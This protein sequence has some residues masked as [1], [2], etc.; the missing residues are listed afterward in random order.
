LDGKR[1]GRSLWSAEADGA[2]G[3]RQRLSRLGLALGIVDGSGARK[4][5][6]STLAAA[7]WASSSARIKRSMA[8]KA[9][10]VDVVR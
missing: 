7:H 5:V 4:T 10:S 3:S 6:F 1:T 9:T 2:S 8:A